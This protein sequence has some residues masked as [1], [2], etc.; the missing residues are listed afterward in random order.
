MCRILLQFILNP[1]TRQVVRKLITNMPASSDN[2]HRVRDHARSLGFDLC[3][4]AAA[5]P[6]DPENRLGQWLAR[7]FHAD[8]DWMART[9]DLRQDVQLKLPGARSVVVVAKNYY[10]PD[11]PHAEGAPRVARYAWGR[12]YH[13]VLK[14]PLKAL[15]EFI[16]TLGPNVQCDVGVDSAPYLE[17]AWAEKAGI[18]WVGRNSL[19]LNREM[20]SWFF[21]GVLATTLELEPD[22]PLEPHCGTCRACIDAC[23]TGAIVEE[24][25]VDSNRCIS[26][27]TI[28]NKNILNVDVAQRMKPW[29]FGC[30]ICQD[31]CPWN[32]FAQQTTE[33][34]FVARPGVPFPE[35]ERLSAMDESQFIAVFG[36]TPVM[37]AKLSGMQRNLRALR[38]LGQGSA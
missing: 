5:G 15:A 26:Y 27:Q 6:I 38:E 22:Q 21:L 10:Q 28:E 35:P 29:I 19:V 4:V 7:G 20:G 23:P 25:I 36:G 24:G 14:K 13:K 33:P 34:D 3:G 16:G 30:D 2:S 1:I 9:Q 12:D 37:R 8:M 32:R 18:G 11:P 17:R 31:V